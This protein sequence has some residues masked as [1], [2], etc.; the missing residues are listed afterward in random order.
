[1]RRIA[2]AALAFLFVTSSARGQ[3]SLVFLCGGTQITELNVA[4][5]HDHNNPT[6]VWIWRAELS[7]GLPDSVKRKFSAIDDC[8]AANNGRDVLVSSSGGAV[9]LVSHQTGAT[10]FYANITNAHSVA[11]LPGG[12]IVAAASTGPS[13][14][15]DRVLLYRIGDSDH[16]LQSMPIEAAH[17]VEWDSLHH[18]LWA[19]GEH[20]LYHLDLITLKGQPRLAEK[21]RI[22]LPTSGGHDLQIGP[23]CSFLLATTQANVYQIDLPARAVSVFYPL[24]GST[25]VKSLS[26]NFSTGQIV[27]TVADPGVWWTYTLR[28]LAPNLSVDL[29]SSLYKAR[30]DQAQNCE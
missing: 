19:L 13:G 11:M 9:A 24:A 5:L 3:Q 20:Y 8:K 29:A 23:K 30:W 26:M 6:P 4:Q 1:M 2:I 16:P 18:V 15:G 10:L 14:T 12:L 28:F 25:N 7:A 27:Y 17:G 22:P 21:E